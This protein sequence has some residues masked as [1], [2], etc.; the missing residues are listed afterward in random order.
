[1]AEPTAEE[2]K[3]FDLS[4][5][6]HEDKWAV[7]YTCAGDGREL[8]ENTKHNTKRGALAFMR[9]N[10]KNQTGGLD[11]MAPWF[12]LDPGSYREASVGGKWDKDKSTLLYDAK[13]GGTLE[14]E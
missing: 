6:I 14:R 1:M 8:R 5:S 4:D 2:E 12:L 11:L 3:S 9:W 13:G 10:V 7:A